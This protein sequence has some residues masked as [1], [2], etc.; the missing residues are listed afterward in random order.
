MKACCTAISRAVH[1]TSG[2]EGMLNTGV[3][4]YG[5][6]WCAEIGVSGSSRSIGLVG[7]VK[8]MEEFSGRLTANL[9][10]GRAKTC[11]FEIT[12]FCFLNCEKKP[13]V[14]RPL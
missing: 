12:V 8:V 3:I 6:G 13:A 2:W 11:Y 10:S 4:E 7:G 9:L 1:E 5:L 14:V